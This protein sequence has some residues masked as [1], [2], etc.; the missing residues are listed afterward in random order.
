MHDATDP[1]AH[2]CGTCR[3]IPERRVKSVIE[4]L[5]KLRIDLIGDP[6]GLNKIKPR[7]KNLEPQMIFFDHHEADYFVRRDSDRALPFLVEQFIADKMPLHQVLPVDLI[8][9]RRR[10]EVRFLKKIRS[11]DSI[12]DFLNKFFR[13]LRE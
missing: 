2:I 5:F 9:I 11:F 13:E 4:M 1:G 8:K 10:Y 12:L 3:K 6:P 7:L